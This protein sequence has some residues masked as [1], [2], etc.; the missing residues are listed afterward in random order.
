MEWKRLKKISK[1]EISKVEGYV[2]GG[3]LSNGKFHTPEINNTWDMGWS[4]TRTEL[5]ASRPS[6][7]YVIKDYLH[8][9]QMMDSFKIAELGDKKGLHISFDSIYRVSGKAVNYPTHI[10]GMDFIMVADSSCLVVNAV[11]SKFNSASKHTYI[12][13]VRFAQMVKRLEKI[14]ENMKKELSL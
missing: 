10:N 7:V 2:L 8:A 5:S 6:P 11:I 13:L 1:Y 14:K 4:D 9:H 12:G 3:R